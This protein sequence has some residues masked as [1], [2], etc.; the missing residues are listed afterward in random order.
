M[1]FHPPAVYSSTRCHLERAV[2][3]QACRLACRPAR[4]VQRHQAFQEGK[5]LLRVGLQL[6]Q[7]RLLLLREAVQHQLQ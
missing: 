3:A 7:Q 6:S 1:Q 4:L 5:L 2:A